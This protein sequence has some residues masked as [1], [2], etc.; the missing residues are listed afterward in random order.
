VPGRPSGQVQERAAGGRATG[1]AI[2][3]VSPRNY[4]SIRV[5][6][7]NSN[8]LQGPSVE[9]VVGTGTNL[10]TWH[11]PK[12]LLGHHSGYF[13]AT[14]NESKVTL[15]EVNLTLFQHFIQWIY[16]AT[17]SRPRATPRRSTTA[18]PPVA[19]RLPRVDMKEVG[20]IPQLWSLGDKLEARLFKNFVMEKIHGK[21][22]AFSFRF[23]VEEAE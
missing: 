13:R 22:V 6:L 19:D 15:S 21:H 5:T 12:A 17:L 3:S 23:S 14:G 20:L 8:S 16:F 11:I 4:L 2:V 1:K 18:P 9:V 10:I 7:I